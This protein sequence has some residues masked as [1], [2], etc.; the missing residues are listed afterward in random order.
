MLYVAMQQKMG[1][2]KP[3]IIGGFK[4]GGKGYIEREYSNAANAHFFG[5]MPL[6]N[7]A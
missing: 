3:A 5:V 6:S 1:E 4:W 2:K 7:A